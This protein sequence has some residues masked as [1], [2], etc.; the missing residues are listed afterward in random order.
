MGS[1]AGELR[2]IPG[3]R[4]REWCE[5]NAD[6]SV[7]TTD[8]W[9]IVFKNAE[10]VYLHD[11]DGNKYMDFGSPGTNFA[12]Y[13][14]VLERHFLPK[15]TVTFYVGMPMF[16]TT[17]WGACETILAKEKIRDATPLSGKGRVFG[18]RAGGAVVE[19]AVKALR[20]KFAPQG[21]EYFL[22]FFGE[23]H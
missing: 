12:G 5:R 6:V 9:K 16:A 10:G 19:T 13:G 23:F 3:P 17:D 20:D 8:P 22:A 18:G 15:I 14:S 21:R 11:V 4:T 7:K 1:E 2:E